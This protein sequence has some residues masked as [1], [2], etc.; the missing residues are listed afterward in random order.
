MVVIVTALVA[1]FTIGLG[2]DDNPTG[3]SAY[4]VFN[5]GFERLL[6]SV[7]ADALLAQ[8]IGG[9]AGGLM[10]MNNNNNDDNDDVDDVDGG[11]I[12]RRRAVRPRPDGA[13]RGEQ[14]DGAELNLGRNRDAND[15]NVGDGHRGDDNNIINEQ[16]GDNNVVNNRARKSGKK[17]RRRNLDQRREIQRQREAAIRMG[18]DHEET[19]EMQMLIEAQIA[20]ENN[21]RND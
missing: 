12:I 18:M 20:A 5:R 21:N 16:N 6:G 17:A 14:D 8:H 10:M 19:I 13:A 1:I 4:S 3:P 15:N 9:G 7:D 2:D 11:R